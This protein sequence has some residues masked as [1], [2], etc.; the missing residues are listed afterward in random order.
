[1]WDGE[2]VKL[3]AGDTGSSLELADLLAD[4]AA[5]TQVNDPADFH[6]WAAGWAGESV[7]LANDA[8]EDLVF[9]KAKLNAAKTKIQVIKLGFKSSLD[10]Y[11]D[12]EK[13]IAFQQ[14]TKATIRLA[15]LLNKILK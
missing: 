7:K 10:S 8:Y 11:E 13:D 14:L 12:V 15:N 6:D 2:L 1:M 9:G 3:A 5:T 4:A